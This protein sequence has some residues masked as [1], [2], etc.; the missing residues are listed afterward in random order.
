MQDEP[1]VTKQDD[2]TYEGLAIDI[3]NKV[4]VELLKDGIDLNLQFIDVDTYGSK[5]GDGRWTGVFGAM[6][7]RVSVA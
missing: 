4:L 7:Y 2:G 6:L 1:F 3:Y 5:L